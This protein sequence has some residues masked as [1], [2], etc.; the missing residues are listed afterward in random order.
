MTLSLQKSDYILQQV[1]PSL[2]EFLNEVGSARL[3]SALHKAPLVS[4]EDVLRAVHP[5]GK[6]EKA[7]WSTTL[8]SVPVRFGRATLTLLSL[9]PFLSCLRSPNGYASAARPQ[10][11]LVRFGR[12][13][14]KGRVRWRRWLGCLRSWHC[15]KNVTPHFYRGL[16]ACDNVSP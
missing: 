15:L 11:L 13:R 8:R 4:P 1:G 12:N 5:F 2:Q 7:G 9:I 6:K 10:P 14:N 3:Q 16:R